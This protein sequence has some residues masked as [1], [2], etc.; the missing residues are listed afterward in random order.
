MYGQQEQLL[1]NC[2]YNIIL[3][4]VIWGNYLG[5]TYMYICMIIRVLILIL[6]I[7][8]I[9]NLKQEI[10]HQL[11]LVSWGALHIMYMIKL[12]FN[13]NIYRGTLPLKY[14]G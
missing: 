9:I 13:N 4:W 3:H 5:Y 12:N 14:D 11:K 2:L 10:S 1:I 7:I 8:I 6:M